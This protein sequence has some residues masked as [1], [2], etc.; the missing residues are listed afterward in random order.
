MKIGFIG[1]GTVTGT[2]GRH[3]MNAG[4]TI[5]VSDSRG[6]ATLAISPPI[7][8]QAPAQGPGS[9]DRVSDLPHQH[10][11]TRDGVTGGARGRRNQALSEDGK[12]S[13]SLWERT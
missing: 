4:H 1:A 8:V 12:Q 10:W 5:V 11:P 3:L 9:T 2:F 13:G 6:P 7:S